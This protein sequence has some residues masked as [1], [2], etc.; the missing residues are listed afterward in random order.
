MKGKNLVKTSGEL[1]A[2]TV[3]G[4]VVSADGVHDYIQGKKQEQ[5]NQEVVAEAK[6][7]KKIA[8]KTAASTTSME[9][10]VEILEKNGKQ[11]IATALTHEIRIEAN[12]N[13][14]Q[15]VQSQ[16]GNYTLIEVD[17][18]TMESLIANNQTDSN[19]LYFVSEVE[20]E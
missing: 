3:A 14:I 12:E 11:D 13:N 16:L 4:T 6:E 15:K 1:Y 7:A 19:T 20:E 5:I 10:V 9:N 18:E 8:E 17:E 2:P